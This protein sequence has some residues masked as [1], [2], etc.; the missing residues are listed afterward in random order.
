MNKN[1][2]R[3][4]FSVNLVRVTILINGLSGVVRNIRTHHNTTRS[5]RYSMTMTGA[6]PLITIQIH[7]SQL[8][9]SVVHYEEYNNLV[10]TFVFCTRH[11]GDMFFQFLIVN[12][13]KTNNNE[14]IP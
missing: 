3:E 2:K 4:S 12:T 9:T 10:G 8:S 5:R 13:S 6:R 11:N 1:H 7:E 14:T